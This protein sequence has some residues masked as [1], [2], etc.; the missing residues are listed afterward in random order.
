MDHNLC[1]YVKISCTLDHEAVWCIMHF[2]QTYSQAV[3]HFKKKVVLLDT[4]LL[5][6]HGKKPHTFESF[7]EAFIN[8]FH[9]R[10]VCV[11]PTY[12]LLVLSY[13][14]CLL[15]HTSCMTSCMHIIM[16]RIAYTHYA[17]MRGVS[18]VHIGIAMV[19]PT[20]TGLLIF[21]IAELISC[22]ISGRYPEICAVVR[23]PWMV[24]DSSTMPMLAS[25]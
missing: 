18:L 16:K 12:S 13:M 23:L 22:R 14:E 15:L 25:C 6:K 20:F 10:R 4:R 11:I 19:K 5:Q 8:V 7:I 1:D 17:Y 3:G 9:D 2:L 21:Y 24:K